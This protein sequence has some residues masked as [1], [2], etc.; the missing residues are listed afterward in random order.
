MLSPPHPEVVRD[1]V[2][3]LSPGVAHVV[4][5]VSYRGQPARSA[6]IRIGCGKATA[7]FETGS[8]AVDV[9]ASPAIDGDQLIRIECSWTDPLGVLHA[10][11]T[12]TLPPGFT[13]LG[14]IELQPPPSW[15]RQVWMH[16]SLEMTHQVYIG[17]DTVDNK[18]PTDTK[19][20]QRDEA[21]L[22]VAAAF[23]DQA[24]AVLRKDPSA[25]AD[26][27]A[28]RAKADSADEAFRKELVKS[29]SFSSESCGGETAVISGTLSLPELVDPGDDPAVVTV[30]WNAELL[31][32]DKPQVARGDTFK[33][34]RRG[35]HRIRVGL[36]DGDDPPDRAYFD[37]TFEN[38]D[39][40]A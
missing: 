26:A 25:V 12:R 36:R 6:E 33:L 24:A 32:G 31:D 10:E 15:R 3:A 19:Y 5:R 29:F 14:D 11:L 38:Q 30:T 28:L 20:L 23:R 21:I 27:N 7:D 35:E 4:G 18:T 40:L 37:L 22:D 2:L 39:Q 1:A 8:F 34:A 17:H 9:S 13:D 16:G